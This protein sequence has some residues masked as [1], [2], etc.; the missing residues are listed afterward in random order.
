MLAPDGEG[1]LEA[2]GEDARFAGARAE[3]VRGVEGGWGAGRGRVVPAH[4]EA[5]HF[6]GRGREGRGLILEGVRKSVVLCGLVVEK[7]V[8]RGAW[9][10]LRPC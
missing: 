2:D 4:V 5:L 9:R 8:A 1:E 10:V 7:C 6:G 3:R